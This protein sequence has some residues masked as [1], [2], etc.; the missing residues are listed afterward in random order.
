MANRA[1]S[2]DQTV[3]NM[4]TFLVGIASLSQGVGKF[5]DGNIAV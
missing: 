4:Y 3:A 5:I 2:N 1:V